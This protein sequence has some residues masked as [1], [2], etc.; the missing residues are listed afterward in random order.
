MF[1]DF[2]KKKFVDET[3]EEQRQDLSKEHPLLYQLAVNG[4]DCDSLFNN[5]RDFGHTIDNPIPVNGVLGEVKYL[6]RLR[7]R[8]GT[9]LMHHRLGSS[10]TDKIKN[11]IN[12]CETVCIK[13]KHWDILYFDVYH[14]RRSTWFPLGYKFSDFHSIFSRYPIGY[15]TN[16]FDNDFPFGLGKYILLHLGMQELVRKYDEVIK[17]KNKFIRPENHLKKLSLI[18]IDGRVS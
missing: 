10:T 5:T 14:P 15:G 7:C 1:L 17:D 9:G 11:P 6:N 2:L 18:N 4:I 16:R 13:G 3:L 12:V 8:C